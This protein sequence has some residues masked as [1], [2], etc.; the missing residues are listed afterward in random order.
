MKRWLHSIREREKTSN[1]K[2]VRERRS[3]NKRLG[4][5]RGGHAS[6]EEVIQDL[7][8]DTGFSL[9]GGGGG[10]SNGPTESQKRIVGA[11]IRNTSAL[12]S[13]RVQVATD[14]LQ[15]VAEVKN[16][17]ID[18]GPDS[19]AARLQFL[20][21]Q[22]EYDPGAQEVMANQ[23]SRTARVYNELKQKEKTG[24]WDW[25]KG[26]W[27]WL[28]KH[29]GWVVGA[30]VAVY[31]WTTCY[32]DS[33]D[34]TAILNEGK[35]T[36]HYN[37]KVWDKGWGAYVGSFF[38]EN[39]AAKVSSGSTQKYDDIAD[40]WTHKNAMCTMVDATRR[41]VGTAL[42]QVVDWT[43]GEDLRNVEGATKNIWGA[44]GSIGGAGAGVV[45]CGA[46]GVATAGIGGLLCAA[47][48]G[49]AGGF[50]GSGYGS[51]AGAANIHSMV[52]GRMQAVISG[53]TLLSPVLVRL[54]GQKTVNALSMAA[55][56][57]RQYHGT[58]QL[59]HNIR[60]Q[61]YGSALQTV[62]GLA[63]PRLG[64]AMGHAQDVTELPQKWLTPDQH[65]MNQMMR[66]Q[67]Q[68]S[69]D[70]GVGSIKEFAGPH[71]ERRS[72]RLARQR[73]PGQNPVQRRNPVQQ[74]VRRNPVQ[75]VRR[76]PVQQ[77]VRNPVRNTR[78]L[79]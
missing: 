69:M 61:P 49:A 5:F 17:P 36:E 14:Y 11:K 10:G 72:K 24:W 8:D 66:Q 79:V 43:Q 52:Q 53:L 71:M 63:D 75:T 59:E 16:K 30:G 38:R 18:T 58:R 35:I 27:D 23:G 70:A 25:L 57:N 50:L 44:F 46:I 62:M 26:I 6:G 19:N 65:R 54:V 7:L 68:K 55:E 76:N 15:E 56:V 33:G 2:L 77:T 78:A 20:E 73:K 51:H 31:L 45:A 13:E 4:Y 12:M 37:D 39:K 42:G 9:S 32:R 74:T 41:Q 1:I 21:A 29:K 60:A 22:W 34:W 28:W 40:K 48:A 64:K 67:T 3:W 47:G